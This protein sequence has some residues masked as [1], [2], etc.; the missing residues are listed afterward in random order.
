MVLTAED[1]D[2]LLNFFKYTN[3]KTGNR[4][5]DAKLARIAKL[6]GTKNILELCKIFKKIN[7]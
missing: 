7:S 3:K 1:T 5:L 2:T 4:I 6:K